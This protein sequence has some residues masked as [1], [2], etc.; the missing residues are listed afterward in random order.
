MK[1]TLNSQVN[2]LVPAVLP[3]VPTPAGDLLNYNREGDIASVRLGQST[4]KSIFKEFSIL[5]DSQYSFNLAPCARA[6]LP[7]PP[8][9]GLALMSLWSKGAASI[10]AAPT[11]PA[12]PPIA[13]K[14]TFITNF[15]HFVAP[16]V[17]SRMLEADIQGS[18]TWGF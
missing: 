8:H 3:A 4:W 17:H 10:H 15:I 7:E 11:T 2:F 9:A 5:P 6:S 13:L 12:L 16:F 1:S 18:S 14:G